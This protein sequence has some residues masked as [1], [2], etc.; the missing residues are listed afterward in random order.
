[1][2]DQ[3]VTGGILAGEPFSPT[4]EN[5]SYIMPT[6]TV[7][8]SDV[9]VEQVSSVLRRE[10]GSRY[11]ITPSMTAAAFGKRGPGDATT[12]LVASNWLERANVRVVSQGDTTEIRV[13]PGATYFGLILLLH[14]AGLAHK[15]YRALE[16]APELVGS[17]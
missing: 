7:P 16:D 2:S 4:T 8:R 6:V 11:T 12:I 13:S 1:V 17:D 5:E 3:V 15:V 14:H 9:S 10:L